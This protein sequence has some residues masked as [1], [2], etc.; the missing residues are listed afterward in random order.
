[1]L[2]ATQNT[3]SHLYRIAQE[4]INNAVRHGHAKTI[5]IELQNG[6]TEAV[7]SVTNDGA[8]LPTKLGRS[9]GMGLHIM[10]YRAEMIGAMLRIVSTAQGKTA[11]I[12]S[13]KP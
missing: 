9:G 7:L 5:A 2:I 8:P 4:A 3:A 6:D 11:V 13:F 10:R 12:C 1:V